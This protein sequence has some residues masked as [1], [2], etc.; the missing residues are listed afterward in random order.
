MRHARATVAAVLAPFLAAAL[1][2]TLDAQSI[3]PSSV[4]ATI[5]VGESITINKTITVGEFGATTVDIF[6]LADNT[7]SMGGVINQA[8]AGANSILSALPNT[9]Q[10]GVGRYIGDPSEGVANS[11]LTNQALTFN[12]TDV[13][14]GINSWFAS[15]GGDTPEGNFFALKE[16]ADNAGWRPEA[17]RL[18]VWFGDAPSHTVTTTEAEAI[19]ALQAA[20]AKV[21]AFNSSSAGFGIDGSFG[22]SANQASSIVA[23]TGGSL[24]NNFSSLTG[25]AFVDAVTAA[26]D[27]ATSTV[28]LVFGS[29]FM[30]SGLSIAFSCTDPLG[31]TGVGAGE[32]RMFDVTITGLAPGTYDFEVFAQGIDAFESDRITVIGDGAEVIPEP[33][34]MLLL[35]TGLLGLGGL[36]WRRKQDE[37]D[38]A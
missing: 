17:Q 23:A 26:I 33:A 6:F 29:T 25:D 4:S 28:D 13:Q 11:Y 8:K 19:A 7:G 21:V 30:G 36:A 20:N 3:N 34:T 37:D 10:F 24:T 14:N 9:Y 35:G 27:E 32:S 2:A 22:G 5:G 16:V 1:P 15:G 18:V 31:C 12:K 38:V